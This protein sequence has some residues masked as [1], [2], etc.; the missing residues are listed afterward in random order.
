MSFLCAEQIKSLHDSTARALSANDADMA[1][2]YERF[3]SEIDADVSKGKNALDSVSLEL[4]RLGVLL[5]SNDAMLY[6]EYLPR[7]LKTLSAQ[8][9]KETLYQSVAYLGMARVRAHFD[10]TNEVFVSLGLKTSEQGDASDRLKAGSDIQKSLFGAATHESMKGEFE[11]IGL[12]LSK[13]CFGDYYARSGLSLKERELI[14][15]MFLA[16]QGDTSAQMLA[17]AKAN[18][19]VGNNKDFL[20]NAINANVVIIGYPRSLNAINTVLKATK[21]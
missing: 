4:S 2:I 8:Q 6:K 14:T 11:S 19:K 15:F 5:A 12:W 10:A 9:V 1:I 17:H 16:A 21:E 18:F 7:A 3:T 20:I 13:N